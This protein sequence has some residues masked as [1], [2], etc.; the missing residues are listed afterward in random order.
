MPG[1]SGGRP[2]W[3]T[4]KAQPGCGRRFCRC[5]YQGQPRACAG[6]TP[7]SAGVGWRGLR[8][9]VGR[10]RDSLET[11]CEEPSG[12]RERGSLW[13]SLQAAE[14]LSA[15]SLLRRLPCG[16]LRNSRNG[17]RHDAR[18]EW[19]WRSAGHSLDS[20]H[21]S[22]EAGWG[23]GLR[24]GLR[25]PCAR[26]HLQEL[27]CPDLYARAFAASILTSVELIRPPQWDGGGC[28]W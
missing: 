28:A 26:L 14:D 5:S 12:E 1:D 8:R 20:S 6:G 22:R 21:A 18:P 17:C 25:I 11:T 16:R 9:G 4:C 19:G 15:T 24:T 13:R 10:R 23:V 7:P 2:G 3:Q 27:L